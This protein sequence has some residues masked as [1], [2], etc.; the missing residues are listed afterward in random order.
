MKYEITVVADTN[1]GDYITE[2][3]Q[4][5]SEDLEDIKPIVEAIKNFKPYK[6]GGR[7]HNHNFPYGE[8][9]REDLGELEIYDIYSEV[10]IE[11]FEDYLPCSE[12]GIHT[13][14]SVEVCP[15]QKKEKLL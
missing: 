6:N 7:T 8:C 3:S 10:D 14:E 12:Y 15:L 13:I 4:I 11:M 9:R 1:D 5:S 2:I